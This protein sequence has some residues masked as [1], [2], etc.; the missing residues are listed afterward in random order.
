MI[1]PPPL[2]TSPSP[3][4]R[5]FDLLVI[6]VVGGELQEVFGTGFGPVFLAAFDAAVDLF[7]RG[8]HVGRGDRQALVPIRRVVH[9]GLLVLQVG[10]R[11]VDQ[12]A[13]AGVAIFCRRQAEFLLAGGEFGDVNKGVMNKA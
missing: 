2:V 4:R 6:V 12:R 13:G 9:A 7:D 1:S 8:F 11:F 10:Q 5:V 3:P